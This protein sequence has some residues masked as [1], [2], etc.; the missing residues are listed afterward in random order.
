MCVCFFQKPQNKNHLT[1][2]WSRNRQKWWQ[3]YW[4]I[5][6]SCSEQVWTARPSFSWDGDLQHGQWLEPAA[7][8]VPCS[9]GRAG[10]LVSAVSA[11]WNWGQAKRFGP[12]PRP[13]CCCSHMCCQLK[14]NQ[15]I[16]AKLVC[17]CFLFLSP[18]CSFICCTWIVG[19]KA[20]VSF[21]AMKI[22]KSI[23]HG[24]ISVELYRKSSLQASWLSLIWAKQVHRL[25]R[26]AW[27]KAVG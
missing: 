14:W 26:L 5:W 4:K 3:F 20:R 19:Q 21:G 22:N 15:L 24:L 9:Q 27:I 13:V 2:K 23:E 1:W 12:V 7:F 10:C 8:H 16:Q 18:Y 17:T 6:P 11:V 25:N